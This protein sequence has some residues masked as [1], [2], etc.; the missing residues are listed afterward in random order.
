MSL[1]SGE[2]VNS[3]LYRVLPDLNLMCH[4]ELLHLNSVVSLLLT[5]HKWLVRICKLCR[6]LMKGR[7]IVCDDRR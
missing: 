5:N 2:F 1:Q 3:A 6:T 7:I 4:C